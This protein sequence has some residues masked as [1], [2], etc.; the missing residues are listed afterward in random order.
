M[1][2]YRAVGRMVYRDD[3]LVGL[4]DTPELAAEVVAALAVV[5]RLL[6][7]DKRLPGTATDTTNALVAARWAC[8]GSTLPFHYPGVCP[9]SPPDTSWVQAT[10]H[11]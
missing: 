7:G 5:G 2:E 8:C 6:D 9:K 3:V 11:L 4:M 10:E 1:A